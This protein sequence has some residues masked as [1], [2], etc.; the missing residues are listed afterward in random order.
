MNRLS[1][2][3]TLLLSLSCTMLCAKAKGSDTAKES[4]NM[5]TREKVLVTYFSR[6]GENY[7]V[8]N[9]TKG[10]TH[11]IAEMIAEATGGRLF[12]IMPTKEYPTEYD[13]C[14][15]LAKKEK[16]KGARP[17]IKQDIAVEDYDIIFIGYPNWWSDM[18]MAVYTFIE[19]HQWKG[20][21]VIPFCTHEGS[22]LSDTESYIAN[23]CKGATVKNGIAIKGSTA[24]NKQE[25]ARK[26]VVGWLERL[27]LKTGTNKK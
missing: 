5:G 26:S 20:K 13:K 10:N 24:Q 8:G 2:I 22:G 27:G 11:I 15:E 23:A 16:E 6:T 19:K 12:E 18:S 3:I 17:A 4:N 21:T 1:I 25:Q 7:G 9:I 14:V